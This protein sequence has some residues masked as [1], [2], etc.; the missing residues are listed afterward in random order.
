MQISVHKQYYVYLN[1]Y[2]KRFE[3]SILLLQSDG[4]HLKRHIIHVFEEKLK[5]YL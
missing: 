4:L 2:V 1:D 5:K 3:S